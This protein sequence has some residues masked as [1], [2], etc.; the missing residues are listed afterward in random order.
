MVMCRKKG[1]IEVVAFAGGKKK[2]K[3]EGLEGI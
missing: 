3:K 1:E 2:E